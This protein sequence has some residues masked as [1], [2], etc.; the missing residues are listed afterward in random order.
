[1]TKVGCVVINPN[2]ITYNNLYPKKF[3]FNDKP[4]EITDNDEIPN[5]DVSE[6]IKAKF[7]RQIAC[8]FGE[9]AKITINDGEEYKINSGSKI[10]CATLYFLHLLGNMDIQEEKK[11]NQLKYEFG[12]IKNGIFYTIIEKKFVDDED[13]EDNT[14]L[15]L[16][17]GS[18]SKL[19]G[20]CSRATRYVDGSVEGSAEF[21]ED[22]DSEYQI[23]GETKGYTIVD[24]AYKEIS[25]DDLDIENING[26]TVI[27]TLAIGER[28][29]PKAGSFI[30]SCLKHDIGVK[31]ISDKTL[32]YSKNVG[33]V[34][35][36]YGLDCKDYNILDHRFDSLSTKKL[37]SLLSCESTI[38]ANT[39][40]K[41]VYARCGASEKLWLIDTLKANG[42]VVAYIGG[43]ESDF[44]VINSADI[45]VSFTNQPNQ[46][47]DIVIS[48]PNKLLSLSDYHKKLVKKQEKCII[49]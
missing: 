8:C 39:Y 31:L 1:M 47:T 36:A 23:L 2:V 16:M 45:T 6:V 42:I 34:T 21:E 11:Q 13:I 3:V 5:F 40:T 27:T 37:E 41:I 22:S 15:L 4:Y 48:D 35:N 38:P 28:I 25:D 18:S 24:F 19:M 29:Y 32:S 30:R 33:Y 7:A 14:K 46:N 17:C 20:H 12:Q 9:M 10:H 49:S 26:L 43:E 44:D